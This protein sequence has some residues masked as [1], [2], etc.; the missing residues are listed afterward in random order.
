MHAVGKRIG[1]RE[2]GGR[3]GQAATRVYSGC[4]LEDTEERGLPRVLEGFHPELPSLLM[5]QCSGE[6]AWGGEGLILD[7]LEDAW[8]V[9]QM[10]ETEDG[11]QRSTVSW[12]RNLGV[13]GMK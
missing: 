10:L 12:E 9:K 3:Q 7:I 2:A 13:S 5:G 4:F 8:N 11:A 6:A 1:E